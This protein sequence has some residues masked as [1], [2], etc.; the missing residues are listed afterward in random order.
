MWNELSPFMKSPLT[1]LPLISTSC[2]VA[3]FDFVEKLAEIQRSVVLR[4]TLFDHGPQQDGH[5]D[6]DHPEYDCFYV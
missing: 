1:S 4:V 2:D 6:Q 3:G 5:A